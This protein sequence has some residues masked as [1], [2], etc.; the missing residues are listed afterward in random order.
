MLAAKASSSTNQTINKTIEVYLPPI[1][2]KVTDPNTIYEYML[3]LQS[4][5]TK[6]NMVYVN[7]TLD[8]GA[9]IKAY[10]VLWTYPETLGFPLHKRELSGKLVSQL[11]TYSYYNYS[12]KIL[13]SILV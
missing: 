9:A 6:V 8:V 3:Y 1:P 11:S 10:K 13:I 5:A 4:I 2:S 12:H 7:I